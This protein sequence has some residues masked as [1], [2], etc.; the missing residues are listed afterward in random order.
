VRFQAKVLALM[1]L[2]AI[3]P[4]NGLDAENLEFA[5]AVAK[6]LGAAIYQM[7]RQMSLTAENRSLRDQLRVESEL[8]GTSPPIKSIE[9]QIA[10]VADTNATILI[11]GESGSG[12]ELV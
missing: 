3:K 11:R 6:H 1:H 8:V 9:S 10:R 4:D 2:Y 5:M 12:K 7:N